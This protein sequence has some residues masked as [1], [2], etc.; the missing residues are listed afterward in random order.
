MMWERYAVTVPTLGDST[1]SG[2]WWSVFFVSAHTDDPQVYFASAPDS[3]YSIDNL[4]PLPPHEFL[5]SWSAGE[6]HLQWQ[7]VQ[8]ED[9][10]HYV[11]Y[12]GA[13][14]TFTPAEAETLFIVGGTVWQDACARP[15][16]CHYLVAAVDHCGNES[17]AVRPV[18][19]SE[20]E[21][22]AHLTPYI[23]M[24]VPSPF[25]AGATIEFESPLQASRARLEIYDIRG[26]R[27]CT[28]VDEALSGGR[29]RIAWHGRDARGAAVASGLYFCRLTTGGSQRVA[30]LLLVE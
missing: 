30:R 13:Y 21:H 28:L 9:L 22:E 4:A 15:Q 17:E 19:L 10:D 18:A 20:V 23:L 2:I 29:H 16:D 7:A 8:A 14:P 11:V 1:T 5:A 6:W 25:P 26:R 3:G 27:V 24:W 12:R